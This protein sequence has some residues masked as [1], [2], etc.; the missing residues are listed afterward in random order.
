MIPVVKSKKA[1]EKKKIFSFAFSLL[2]LP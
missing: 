2:V 1:K